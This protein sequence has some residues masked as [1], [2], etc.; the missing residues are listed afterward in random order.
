MATTFQ[1]H[2]VQQLFWLAIG[3][4]DI[5]FEEVTFPEIL[6]PGG[7]GGMFFPHSLL[8]EKKPNFLEKLKYMQ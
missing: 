3:N 7:G 4:L 1:L 2:Y 6:K 8:L 5:I